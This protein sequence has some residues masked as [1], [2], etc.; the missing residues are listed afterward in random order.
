M[1]GFKSVDVTLG[2]GFT[3]NERKKTSR[4]CDVTIQ[5]VVIYI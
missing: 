2:A 3:G 5:I 1:H 4:H